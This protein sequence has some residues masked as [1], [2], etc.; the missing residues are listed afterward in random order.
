[1]VDSQ[2]HSSPE[3][4]G[5]AFWPSFRFAPAPRSHFA[6]PGQKRGQDRKTIRH[7]IDLVFKSHL[8]SKV[9]M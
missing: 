9:R 8:E 1:M 7:R 5:T 4:H 3:I 6:F 2:S